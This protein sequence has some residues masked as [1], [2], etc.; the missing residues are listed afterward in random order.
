MIWINA[1]KQFLAAY[2]AKDVE[3]LQ[4][5]YAD[6]IIW[7]DLNWSAVGK[8]EVLGVNHS[9]FNSNESISVRVQNSC[10]KDKYVVIEA[11][12]LLSPRNKRFGDDGPAINTA[13]IIQFN[14]FG[15]IQQV[16][17]YRR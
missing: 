4:E 2:A 3:Y 8:P 11:I 12:L 9:F 1:A 13:F 5:H 15:K 17:V 6:D 7:Y 16:S 10:Y 14:S